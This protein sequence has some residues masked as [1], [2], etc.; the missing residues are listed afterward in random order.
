M[1]LHKWL[2]KAGICSLRKAEELIDHGY[3]LVNG[4]KATIGQNI[5]ETQ[6]DIV[7]CGKKV[8]KQKPEQH[9][10]ILYKPTGVLCS[11]RREKGKK[12]IQ[13][14][15]AVK[16]LPVKVNGVGRLDLYSE[17]LLLLTN[18]GDFAN[19]V[20]HP[21]F[22]VLKVYHVFSNAPLPPNAFTE[23]KHGLELEDGI[24]SADLKALSKK[25]MSY[26][27]KI[28]VGRNRIVRRIFEHYG[29]H[30]KKLV[31]VQV[32]KWKLNPK[33]KAGEAY[34]IQKPKI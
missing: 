33:W 15:E 18:D 1:R 22:E 24:V 12:C 14:L 8:P 29:L 10:Y 17:G 23:I 30:V 31:R 26:E 19:K 11:N 2:S 28:H 3:I 16:K 9:Y 4:E 5:D 21:R 7:V 6:D 34:P 20:M 25:N 13:D 27:V 32:G